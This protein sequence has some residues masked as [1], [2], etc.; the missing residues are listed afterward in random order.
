[1]PLQNVTTGP[2][3]LR[4]FRAAIFL[5][6]SSSLCFSAS[7]HRFRLLAFLLSMMAASARRSAW[8]M[9]AFFVASS[10]LAFFS[11]LSTCFLRLISSETIFWCSCCLL[12]LVVERS[13]ARVGRSA[14]EGSQ[15]V[16]SDFFL[17]LGARAAGCSMRTFFLNLAGMA[18]WGFRLRSAVR[19]SRAWRSI[20]FSPASSSAFSSL[21]SSSD[22]ESICTSEA[23]RWSSENPASSSSEAKSSSRSES[24]AAGSSFAS[25]D[26]MRFP[27]V[28]RLARD[29]ASHSTF[30]GSAVPFSAPPSASSSA[31]LLLRLERS[32]KSSRED[33]FLSSWSVAMAR[34]PLG[35]DK[36]KP[37][38]Y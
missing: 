36:M 12:C 17:G 11:I 31:S 8:V 9:G 5:R 14:G 20:S 16:L 29:V 27:A 32:D 28:V 15:L 25:I 23:S 33:D 1:M 24:S 22:D 2:S 35:H 13:D 6:R 30:W 37:R 19:F 7:S 3:S 26:F 21:S 38:I 4:L 34:V 18:S 10:C